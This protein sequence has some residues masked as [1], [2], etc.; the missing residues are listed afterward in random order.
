M[1]VFF[2]FPNWIE[3]GI[4]TI[5]DLKFKNGKLC[6]CYLCDKVE[7]TNKNIFSSISKLKSATTEI[8]REI[9][10]QDPDHSCTL[11]DNFYTESIG[12][13]SQLLFPNNWQQRRKGTK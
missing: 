8:A 2:Y 10:H 3:S 9:Q 7:K 13:Q 4:K 6:E 5:K 11:E 12:K 1:N